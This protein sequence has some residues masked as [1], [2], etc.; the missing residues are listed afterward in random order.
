LEVLGCMALGWVAGSVANLILKAPTGVPTDEEVREELAEI[1]FEASSAISLASKARSSSPFVVRTVDGRLLFVKV[2][3]REQRNADLLWK[4]WRYAVYR[5][6]EDEV[7]FAS[8]KQQV[9][10]E[11]YLALLAAQAGA[12]V[13][14]VLVA[15]VSADGAGILILEGIE[16][17][18]LE[19]VRP[20]DVSVDIL[21]DA[22]KQAVRLREARIAHRD[23]R[24]S[25]LLLDR[26]GKVWVVDFGFGEAAAGQRRLDLDASELLASLALLAGVE[27]AVASAARVAGRDVIAATLPFLQPFG[28]VPATRKQ[29]RS[30]PGLLSELRAAAARTAG[31]QAPPLEPLIRWR[32]RT[33]FG[34]AAGLFAIHVLLPQLVELPAIARVLHRARWEWIAAAAVASAVRYPMAALSLVSALE[35][36]VS[37]LRATAAQLASS[38]ANRAAPA[39]LGGVALKERFLERNGVERPGAVG[40]LAT[41][42]LA[43]FIVHLLG[44]MAVAA[45]LG[46]NLLAQVKLPHGWPAAG[47]LALASVVGGGLLWFPLVRRKVT[48]LLR[49]QLHAMAAALSTPLR[50]AALFGGALGV[51][52]GYALTLA[53]ALHAFGAKLALI[54][55]IAVYLAGSALASASPTPGGLGVIEAAL[56][57]GLTAFGAEPAPAVAGVLAYRLLTFWLTIIPGFVAFRL[58]RR[59]QLL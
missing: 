34:L 6:I 46:R 35:R 26:Q 43:G 48:V 44:L 58:L 54:K 25:N 27:R 52:L 51:N 24:S 10:H 7:P 36:P 8:P 39:G 53:A 45:Y 30:K 59:R 13:P 31:V 19:E 11:A 56:V 41:S 2:V 3:S 1:G 23:L 57:T 22:W 17:E 49:G 5:E 15:A 47:L 50:A 20:Q 4:L 14:E 40:A 38:W 28:L 32:W 9:E 55:I 12:R 16:G 29:M 37:V 21:D 33:I 18:S 42:Q